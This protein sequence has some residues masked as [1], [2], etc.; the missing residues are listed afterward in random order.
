M[1]G[2]YNLLLLEKLCE[3][4]KSKAKSYKLFSFSWTE[5]K[6]ESLELLKRRKLK[7]D[8]LFSRSEATSYKP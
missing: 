6:A 2:T 5:M 3:W 1:R 8:V 7:V 4:E